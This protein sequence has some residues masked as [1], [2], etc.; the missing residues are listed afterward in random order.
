M[1]FIYFNKDFIHVFN[2]IWIV[3]YYH[4]GK[5]TAKINSIMKFIKL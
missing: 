4:Y 2:P 5:I 1:T 3:H